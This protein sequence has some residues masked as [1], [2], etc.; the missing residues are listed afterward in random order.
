MKNLRFRTRLSRL[1][2]GLGALWRFVWRGPASP[3]RVHGAP[4]FG[5]KACDDKALAS[6]GFEADAG[7]KA[8]KLGQAYYATD[9]NPIEYAYAVPLDRD[10]AFKHDAPRLKLVGL[11]DD[12]WVALWEDWPEACPRCGYERFW[13]L[14]VTKRR[15]S[16]ETCLACPYCGKK[17]ELNWRERR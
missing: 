8:S 16:Q 15:E 11:T 5:L 4:Y 7:L 10:D 1:A 2:Y 9:T 14:S 13:Y 17:T 6:Y 3:L 12:E